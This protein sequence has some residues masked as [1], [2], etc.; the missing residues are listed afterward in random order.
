MSW[1][2]SMGYPMPNFLVQAI[3]R[4][5]ADRAAKIIQD[6]LGIESDDVANY[7]FPKNWPADREQRARIIGEWLQTE[8]R[9]VIS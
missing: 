8:A 5:D 2:H 4:D 3:N 9:F 1:G 6:A 7:C